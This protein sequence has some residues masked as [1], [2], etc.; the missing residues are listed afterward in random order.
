MKKKDAFPTL[1]PFLVITSCMRGHPGI[2]WEIKIDGRSDDGRIF[3]GGFD[4]SLNG[5][6]ETTTEG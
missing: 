6:K 4:G 5:E 1:A 3:L 2:V